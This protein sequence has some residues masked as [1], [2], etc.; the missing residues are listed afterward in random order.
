MS[1]RSIP[2]LAVLTLAATLWV[3]PSIGSQGMGTIGERYDH[4]DRELFRAAAPAVGAHK[5]LNRA[6]SQVEA[7][8][9]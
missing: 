6:D 5:I 9:R 8:L 4:A 1:R 2:V 3:V 7:S